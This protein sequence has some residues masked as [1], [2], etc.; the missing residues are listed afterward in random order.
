ML[1]WGRGTNAA[2]S[3]SNNVLKER[4]IKRP[5]RA[6]A[7]RFFNYPFAAFEEAIVN[8]VYHRSYEIREPIEIRVNPDCIEILSYPGPDLSINIATLNQARIVARRYRNRRVGDFLKELKLTEGRGTGIPKIHRALA[9]N[10]SPPL[11]IEANPERTFF[12][13]RI[14]IHRDFLV[15]I[16]A[17]VQVE[18]SDKVQVDLNLLALNATELR[19][20]QI[21]QKRPYAGSEILQHLGYNKLTGNV[22]ES[23]RH[24]RELELLTYTIPDKPTSRLQKYRATG[25]GQGYVAALNGS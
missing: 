2:E 14:P 25:K 21:C 3:F 18:V 24:L 20:L 8:A 11:I 7:E 13:V 5:D 16:Q 9:A 17:E 10:G 22:R 23:L 15:Q 6:D 1:Q 12:L 4:V 19:I